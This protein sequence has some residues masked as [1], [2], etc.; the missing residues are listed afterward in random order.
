VNGSLV[1]AVFQGTHH[2]DNGLRSDML[3][4]IVQEFYSHSYLMGN[5][6]FKVLSEK[7]VEL[8]PSE[9]AEMY[10]QRPCNKQGSRGKLVDKYKNFNKKLRRIK[11]NVFASDM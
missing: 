2:L 5:A 9:S 4:T 1:L 10:Y 7:I 3:D 11:S 6:E 8:F